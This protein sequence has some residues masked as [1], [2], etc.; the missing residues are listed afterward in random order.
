M[1]SPDIEMSEITS[2]TSQNNM[3]QGGHGISRRFP[4]EIWDQIFMLMCSIPRTIDVQMKQEVCNIPGSQPFTFSYFANSE[5]VPSVLQINHSS[6][7]IAQR[8]YGKSFTNTKT[9]HYTWINYDVDT[10]KIELSVL[11]NVHVEERALLQQLIL[12]ARTDYWSMSEFYET[13]RHMYSIK[14]IVILSKSRLSCWEGYLTQFWNWYKGNVGPVFNPVLDP[15][16][17]EMDV[18]VSIVDPVTREV[19]NYENEEDWHVRFATEAYEAR[20]VWKSML[21]NRQ[22]IEALMNGD[23]FH[24]GE[25]VRQRFRR[26]PRKVTRI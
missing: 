1:S 16:E 3:Q 12:D 7:K 5:S 9:D 19:M 17:K 26:T 23:A 14:S 6:R 18:D 15:M 24:Y 21:V 8:L 25:E 20:Q 2:T 22:S 4:P 10:V 11:C 13:L